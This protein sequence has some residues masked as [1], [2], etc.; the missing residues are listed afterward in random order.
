MHISRTF[1]VLGFIIMNLKPFNVYL[2]QEFSHCSFHSLAHTHFH[3]NTWCTLPVFTPQLCVLRMCTFSDKM[4]LQ[5]RS[6]DWYS[7]L[8]WKTANIFGKYKGRYILF[9]FTKSFSNVDD[10]NN[11]NV[12]I[13]IFIGSIWSIASTFYV[14]RM[15]STHTHIQNIFELKITSRSK[16]VGIGMPRIKALNYFHAWVTCAHNTQLLIFVQCFPAYDKIKLFRS[17]LRNLYLVELALHMHI[18]CSPCQF[19]R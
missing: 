13:H 6:I 16:S 2:I 1:K 12:S 3:S 14:Y 10:N 17:H 11:N 19:I 7:C 9:A 15:H 5:H 8:K 18:H 4:V